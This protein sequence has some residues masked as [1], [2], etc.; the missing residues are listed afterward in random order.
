MSIKLTF[1]VTAP[2]TATTFLRGQLDFLRQ[3][4][5]AVSV[6]CA[7]G[8]NLQALAASEQAAIHTVP[9]EREISPLRDAVALWHIY[10]TLRR[11][12]PD[13]VN[14]STPKAGLLGML[15]AWLARVPVRVYQQRGLR[16]ETTTGLKRRILTG[17][18]W[19]AARCATVVVCNSA[20]L[21]DA[22]AAL[23]L[24]PRGKLRVLGAGSSNGVAVAS[25]QATPARQAAASRLRQELDIPPQVPVLG[26]VGRFTRDKGIVELMALFAQLQPDFPDLHLLLVGD[27]E[28]GDPVPAAAQRQI[29][30]DPQI[31]TVGFVADAAPYYHLMDL[32]VF[33]SYREG[34]PNVPLEAAAAGVPTV[35]FQATGVV[36]AVVDG[37]TGRLVPIG[38][39]A[40][41]R[42]VSTELLQDAAQ[43]RRLGKQAQVRVARDFDQAQV[44]ENWR[45][46]YCACLQDSAATGS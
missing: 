10:R 45:Q 28:A 32:L 39:M 41:L 22:F 23:N 7:P 13:I 43:R 37:E 36:D 27:F 46:F 25:F 42:R 11:L 38:D 15:A 16:L 31:H 19:L 12:R 17:T 44:W 20:S 14:A 26:F 18:E 1:L 34:L 8:A 24:A 9:M 33:L 6:V 40:Q 30:D 2:V 3:R 35:G 5:F 29:A 21:L 4:D